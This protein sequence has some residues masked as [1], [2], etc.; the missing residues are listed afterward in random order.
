[1][2]P[3]RPRGSNQRLLACLLAGLLALAGSATAAAQQDDDQALSYQFTALEPPLAAPDFV[4]SDMDG[5]RHTLQDYR[6]KVVLLN[7]WATWCPP[8]R[9]EMPALEQLYLRLAE[10]GFVVLAVNQWEDPDHVFAYTG[11]LNVFPT[12]PILFDPDSSVSERF[13]V[14]GLPT[15]FLLDQDG[16]VRYRAIGGRAFNH[17]EVDRTIRALLERR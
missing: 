10:Q 16:R 12:F 7:F 9:R 2:H 15:S 1:V 8:C 17:P 5:E 11:E 14:K 13:G 3:Y 4:L 6:G